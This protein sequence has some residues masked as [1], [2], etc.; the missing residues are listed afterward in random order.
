MN[1]FAVCF[2]IRCKISI[3]ANS[4]ITEI[5]SDNAVFNGDCSGNRSGGR[6]FDCVNPYEKNSGIKSA[7]CRIRIGYERNM[8]IAFSKGRIIFRCN[9]K[10]LSKVI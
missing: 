4:G 3:H 2:V 8:S 10:I 1:F 5:P 9:M 6:T 7:C